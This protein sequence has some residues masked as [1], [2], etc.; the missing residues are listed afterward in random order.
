MS[1]QVP[2]PYIQVIAEN[3]YPYSYE[4][5]G[6]VMGRA[7]ETV[8]KVMERAG[9]T[10]DI[11]LYPWP[12]TLRMAQDRENL[13]ISAMIKTPERERQFQFVGQVMEGDKLYFFGIKGRADIK[14]EQADD[15]KVYRVATSQDSAM[16]DFLR[17]HGFTDV[18]PLF[19]ISLGFK[20]LRYGRIDLLLTSA[21]NVAAH[22]RTGD[23]EAGS[24][25]PYVWAFDAEPH[26]AFSPQ[27]SPV[28][29]KQTREA[30]ESLV[31]EGEIP[32]F[33]S[34]PFCG[35]DVLTSGLEAGCSAEIDG[36]TGG[37]R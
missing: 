23:I 11:A 32:V 7:T 6:V 26:M 20:Q 24:V 27:T 25:V 2:V 34:K 15:A 33:G 37:D 22:V 13:L 3:W 31:K 5:N 17:L 19:D 36:G 1:P 28:V 18:Q 30:Y 16:M 29:V 14:L 9:Y 12:R 8:R 35:M 4:E 21:V 10:Y